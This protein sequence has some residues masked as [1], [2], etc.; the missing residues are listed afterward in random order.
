MSQPFTL[1]MVA[2]KALGGAE[3][4]L[5]RFSIGLAQRKAPI[6]LAIRAGSALDGL[7]LAGLA[8]HRL[9][10]RTTWDPLSR[11][12]VTQLIRRL[13]P[14]IVQTYM[15]R[16][17][18]LTRI[19]RQRG[20]IHIARLGGYYALGPYRHAHE[21]IGNTKALCDWMVQQGLPAGRVHQ[22]Y[23]FAPAPH[24]IGERQLAARRA[25][26]GIPDD[27][28][29]LVAL[30][31]LVPVKGHAH[32][33]AALARLPNEIEG[34][35]LRLVIV[36]DGPLAAA[37]QD[38]ARQCGEDRRIIWTGWQQEPAPYLQMADI[39]VFPS[40]DAE[41]LGNV[42]L[43]AW[44]WQRP[45]VTTSFRGARELARHG[46]DAWCVPCADP[47][48]LADGIRIALSDA[49]LR[50]GLAARGHARI[51]QEFSRDVILDQYQA[52]YRQLASR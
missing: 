18:R 13:E 31:R 19:P 36:G 52:L 7:D 43:E 47:D 3:H 9:P 2:S 21:W 25:E 26:H 27:A 32:L 15:G 10:F 37:L 42:I 17:T 33:I 8:T 20:P 44:S 40:L 51:T 41:T 5:L 1:Q 35:P 29:V 28:W 46:E 22:I 12:A 14:D 49:A 39:I 48:A 34:R 11:R 6:A 23:N 4:W 16:A 38:Q 50:V 45:L 24:P 30:G